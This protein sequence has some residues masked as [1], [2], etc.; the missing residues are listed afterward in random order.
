ML[1]IP[2]TSAYKSVSTTYTVHATTCSVPFQQPGQESGRHGQPMKAMGSKSN[3]AVT[4][5]PRQAV[6]YNLYAKCNVS[7]ARAAGRFSCML[8]HALLLARP[9]RLSMSPLCYT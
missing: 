5:L 3:R 8:L 7:Q 9:A 1:G 6:T 4:S 2:K